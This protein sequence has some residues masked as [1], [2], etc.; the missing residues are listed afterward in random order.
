[1]VSL[2]LVALSTV[3]TKY[4]ALRSSRRQHRGA[5]AISW[6]RCPGSGLSVVSAASRS[7]S[8]WPNFLPLPFEALGDGAEGLVLKF[9]G[10][11]WDSTETS[12]WKTVLIS[13]VTR[14]PSIT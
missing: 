6:F 8:D 7:S 3:L 9:A 4:P 10:S 1:M 13:T 2:I 5:M 14:L 12:C 11:I